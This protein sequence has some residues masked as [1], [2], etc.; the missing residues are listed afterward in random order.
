MG[1][2]F[3]PR[4]LQRVGIDVYVVL[5]GAEIDVPHCIGQNGKQGVDIL[6]LLAP[7]SKTAAGVV[8]AQVVKTCRRRSVEA[9]L[10]AQ[11]AKGMPGL[12]SFQALIMATNQQRII[13]QA[14]G[15]ST[16]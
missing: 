2:K 13:R 14:A 6:I 11:A 12:A 5:S 4:A 7:A 10:C 1:V 8:V 3:G 15:M 9:A 16:S